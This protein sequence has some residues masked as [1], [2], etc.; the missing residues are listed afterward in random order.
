MKTK[1]LKMQ[2]LFEEKGIG[3]RRLRRL[4]LAGT[5]ACSRAYTQTRLL[6]G[7]TLQ[8]INNLVL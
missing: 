8:N 1:R 3:R 6:R 4:S 7:S 5:N 2:F